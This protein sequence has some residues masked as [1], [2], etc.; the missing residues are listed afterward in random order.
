M[1][2][3]LLAP[4]SRNRYTAYTAIEISCYNLQPERAEDSVTG[5]LHMS[6]S[7]YLSLSDPSPLPICN[8]K[9]VWARTVDFEVTYHTHRWWN[10]TVG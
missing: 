5:L 2:T 9:L 4:V 6:L 8:H 10:V 3:F 1:I 7:L